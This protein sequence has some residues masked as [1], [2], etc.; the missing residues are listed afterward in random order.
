MEQINAP[1]APTEPYFRSPVFLSI[2]DLDLAKGYI[3]GQDYNNKQWI[4]FNIRSNEIEYSAQTE[5]EL[6]SK[7]TELGVAST[8]Y[9]LQHAKDHFKKVKEPFDLIIFLID[10]LLLIIIISIPAGILFGIYKIIRKVFYP[11]QNN[12]IAPVDVTVNTSVPTSVPTET[13]SEAVILPTATKPIPPTFT[14]NADVFKRLGAI[15]FILLAFLYVGSTFMYSSGDFSFVSMFPKDKPL[16][17]KALYKMIA[18]QEVIKDKKSLTL[19]HEK[20]GLLKDNLAVY[21]CTFTF[22][23]YQNCLVQEAV[24]NPESF[25]RITNIYGQDSTTVYIVDGDTNRYKVFTKPEYK[26]FR[27]YFETSL[28][29][30]TPRASPRE[31]TEAGDQQA[32]VRNRDSGGDRIKSYRS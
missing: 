21:R 17:G 8:L 13:I 32:P 23:T 6:R 1:G 3:A 24:K 27:S 10:A 7:L 14:N 4:L 18:N 22:N 9:D 15:V 26:T 28:Q 5:T 31:A 12:P 29:C 19:L 16:G 20:E 2:S 11:V 25:V 30:R